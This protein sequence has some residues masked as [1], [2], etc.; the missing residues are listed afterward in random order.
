QESHR[1]QASLPGCR[2][3]RRIHAAGK[4]D[5]E[6]RG[7]HPRALRGAN[8]ELV[9]QGGDYPGRCRGALRL[10][11]AARERLSEAGEWQVLDIRYRAPR[12]DQSG[13]VTA[14]GTVTVWFNGKKVQDG[15][16][17]GEPR[18]AFHPFRFGTTPYLEKIR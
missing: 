16:E 18:S 4:G 8:T 11:Q 3:P 1:L 14:N 5:R 6:Q 17:F 7:L 15:A 12:R 9:R 10:P 2:H 13:K